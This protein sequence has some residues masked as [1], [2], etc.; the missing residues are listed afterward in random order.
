MKPRVSLPVHPARHSTSR[1][2]RTRRSS[3]SFRPVVRPE[4][5]VGRLANLV[6]LLVV[7]A[8]GWLL[9]STPLW[10]V[11]AVAAVL[12][13]PFVLVTLVVQVAGMA[14]VF[15]ESR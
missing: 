6:A 15:G 9:L 1:R 3:D 4:G 13:L 11:L 12:T 8:V 14:V 2:R 10:V 7:A 5:G